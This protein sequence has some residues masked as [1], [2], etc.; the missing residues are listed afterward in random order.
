MLLLLL[1]LFPDLKKPF[2]DLIDIEFQIYL[3]SKKLH[4][5]I[6]E[7]YPRNIVRP[8]RAQNKQNLNIQIQKL[9]LIV[10]II[11]IL[12]LT[13]LLLLLKTAII[14]LLLIL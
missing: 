13:I 7:K 4:N 1:G 3:P 11:L 2:P 9:Q 10:L 6:I 12:T 14:L 8:N 5:P